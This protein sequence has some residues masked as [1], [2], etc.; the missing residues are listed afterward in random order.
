VAR[1]GKT[2]P[3]FCRNTNNLFFLAF[4]VQHNTKMPKRK[5]PVTPEPERKQLKTPERTLPSFDQRIPG[6]E[7]DTL[8]KAGLHSIWAW[9]EY[10]S[11]KPDN[12]TIFDFFNIQKTQGYK[13]LR[14]DSVHALNSLFKIPNYKSI[15]DVDNHLLTYK[16]TKKSPTFL[17][18]KIMLNT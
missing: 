6:T 12:N 18:L 17:I 13:I 5:Q 15:L 4:P 16:S 10:N 14:A 3:E 11:R 2:Y 7:Y 9:E 8:H 1:A